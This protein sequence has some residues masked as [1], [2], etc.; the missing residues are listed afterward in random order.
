MDTEWLR[1]IS[2]SVGSSDVCSSVEQ[3]IGLRRNLQLLGTGGCSFLAVLNPR[4]STL[5]SCPT[6]DVN[7]LEFYFL[8]QEFFP[9]TQRVLDHLSVSAKVM[10]AADTAAV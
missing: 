4:R 5:I 3:Y 2:A 6:R 1:C 8:I 7:L 9:T 10:P